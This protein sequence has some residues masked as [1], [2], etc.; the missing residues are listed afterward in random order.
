MLDGNDWEHALERITL[1]MRW[2]TEM[3][4]VGRV[5]QA[6]SRPCPNDLSTSHKFPYPKVSIPCSIA[7]LGTMPLYMDLFVE[8]YQFSNNNIAL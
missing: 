5:P 4:V 6:L 7:T 8:Y 2:E 1:M 3:Q